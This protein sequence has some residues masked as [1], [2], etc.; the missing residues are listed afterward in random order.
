[1]QQTKDTLQILQSVW[2]EREKE[3]MQERNDVAR[4]EKELQQLSKKLCRALCSLESHSKDHEGGNNETMVCYFAS[5]VIST[6][7]AI[8]NY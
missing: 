5:D 6:I 4:E 2:T 1:M 3:L 8:F 7:D